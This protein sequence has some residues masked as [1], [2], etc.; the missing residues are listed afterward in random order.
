MYVGPDNRAWQKIQTGLTP[1]VTATWEIKSLS[2]EI[3]EDLKIKL[4]EQMLFGPMIDL[5]SDM[6]ITRQSPTR[7][8]NSGRESQLT[9]GYLDFLW[10]RCRLRWQSKGRGQLLVLPSETVTVNLYARAAKPLRHN[11]A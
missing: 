9:L 6:L 4:Q 3:D 11:V 10:S 5:A 7:M 8:H 2:P 1:S